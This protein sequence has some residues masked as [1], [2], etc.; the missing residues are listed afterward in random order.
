[1]PDD[2]ILNIKALIY[3]RCCKLKYLKDER[4]SSA[5]P[6]DHVDRAQEIAYLPAS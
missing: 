2:E 5:R 1:M 6:I 3:M 4:G